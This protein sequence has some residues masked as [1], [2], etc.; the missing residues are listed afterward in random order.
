MEGDK[1]ILDIVFDKCGG[2]GERYVM[3]LGIDLL[4]RYTIPYRQWLD[5]A[6]DF[7]MAG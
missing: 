4:S 1:Y 7:I 2:M 3:I 6:Q 5:A